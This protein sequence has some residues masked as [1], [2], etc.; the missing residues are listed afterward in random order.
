NVRLSTRIPRLLFRRSGVK[1]GRRRRA[2]DQAGQCGRSWCVAALRAAGER[3]DP[4]PC[5]ERHPARPNFAPGLYLRHLAEAATGHRVEQ[6]LAL[7]ALIVPGQ[8]HLAHQIGIGLLE[9]LMP[10]EYLREPHDAALAADAAD[11]NRLGYDGHGSYATDRSTRSAQ[12]AGKPL[13]R[14]ISSCRSAS[15]LLGP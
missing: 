2:P 14:P 9:S 8:R 12:T 15:H 10:F 1:F 3:A 11:L 6:L 7:R 5:L 4:S 13:A